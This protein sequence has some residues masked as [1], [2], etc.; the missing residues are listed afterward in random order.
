M[1]GVCCIFADFCVSLYRYNTHCLAT[2]SHERERLHPSCDETLFVCP[3]TFT[4]CA[5]YHEATDRYQYMAITADHRYYCY[6]HRDSVLYNRYRQGNE[7]Y[8]K[9]KSI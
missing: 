4:H 9:R 2:D 5:S 1:D 6:Q 3:T 7:S 8:D